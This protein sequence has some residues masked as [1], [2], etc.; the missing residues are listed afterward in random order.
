MWT[1]T[2]TLPEIVT[3]LRAARR[4][5]VLTHLKPDGDAVGSSIALVR[6]LNQP[7]PWNNGGS[8]RAKAWYYGPPPPWIEDIAGT[9][10]HTVLGR[11]DVPGAEQPE[12]PD[13]IA[14]L[15]TGSWTQL[16]P[17][18]DWLGPR[19]QRAIIVDHHA[20]GDPELA[21]L[22][23]INVQSAAVCE[24]VAE[25]CRQLLG[26]DGIRDLPKDI[27]TPLYLGLAT[28]TG[29]FRHSNVTP[30][31]MHTAAELLAAG[32][33]H[34]R[35]YSLTEQNSR[36]RLALI[37]RA[38]ASIELHCGD[39]LALM[40]VTEQDFRE[41]GAT[42]GDA[43]GLT[44]FTQSL[45]SVQ[46]SAFFSAASPSEFG[47]ADDGKPVTKI[48]LRSKSFEPAV[49]VNI[50]AKALGGGGHVRAAGT[51]VQ[52]TIREAKERIIEL[53]SAQFAAATKG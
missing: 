14:V 46:V 19:S 7:G 6:A 52:A 11:H 1:S 2:T 26:V 39:R 24:I 30:G 51:R 4:V 44:D 32:A 27:A 21:P 20:Q 9:T 31:V 17:V 28:D 49:D 40:C 16:E 43:G 22:R 42:P 5:L 13:V 25:L 35:L 53:V 8:P 36:A 3:K 18:A 23:Y 47:L 33:E 15:D 29:W 41:T 10:P 48:S 12:E 38:L 37:G 34:V 45:P 50:V